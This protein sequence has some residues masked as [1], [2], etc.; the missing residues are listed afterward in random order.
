MYKVTRHT[1]CNVGYPILTYCLLNCC[2]VLKLSHSQVALCNGK[3]LQTVII[4]II[5]CGDTS[6]TEITDFTFQFKQ[7]NVNCVCGG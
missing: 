3:T 5:L 4:F 1:V 2:G 7:K 6:G